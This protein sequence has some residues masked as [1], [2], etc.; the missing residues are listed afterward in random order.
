MIKEFEIND[1]ESK[2]AWTLELKKEQ[3]AK[4]ALMHKWTLG[5]PTIKIPKIMSLAQQLVYE[6]LVL[7]IEINEF[8][9][10]LFNK[11]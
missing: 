3:R 2:D 1:Y 5:L 6:L 9:M 11:Y 10:N 7:G 8:D 4:V